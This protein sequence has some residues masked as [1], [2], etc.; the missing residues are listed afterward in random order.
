MAEMGSTG[1]VNIT[2]EMLTNAKNA[3]QAY[4]DTA[5]GLHVRL[6]ATVSNLI[7]GNFS[8]SAATGFNTF[9]NETIQQVIGEKKESGHTLAQILNSLDAMLDGIQQ[10]IPSEQGV[11][12]ELGKGNS[13][14]QQ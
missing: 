7:P 11:D 5:E 9:Y 3:V 12:E 14:K 10:A 8:G 2:H 1:I 13:G 4:R 6:D